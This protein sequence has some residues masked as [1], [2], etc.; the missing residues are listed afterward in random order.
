VEKA[1][2]QAEEVVMIL[3][4][5]ATGQL[6]SLVVRELRGQGRQVRAMVRDPDSARDLAETGAELVTADLRRPETLDA[7]LADVQ[8]VVATANVVAPTRPGDTSD[9]LDAGYRDLVARCTSRGVRRFVMASVPAGDL[10]GSVPVARTKRRLERL[11]GDSGLSFASLRLP[12]FTE[13]WLAL[14]G[15]SLPLRDEQRPNLGRPY[16]FLR[17]FRRLTGSSVERHGVMIV[18]GPASARHAFISIHDVARLLAAA[19]DREAVSGAVDVGG[20]E[21][22]SWTD[23]SAVFADVLGRRVR[24]VSVPGAV[25]AAAQRV[26]APVAPS[27]SDIMGLDRLMASMRTD[28]DTAEVAARL[29]VGDL[30]TV[31]QVLREKAALAT[32]G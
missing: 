18:P 3:V 4:V 30:R 8:A 22:L 32:V 26:L 19:V 25:F 2:L 13:V 6:G 9:A 23:V 17:G 27:V 14:V 24:V 31:E 28:W 1:R 29:G 11:L 15:S 16:R 20:P 7:A 12:P 21:V 5:G 10:D